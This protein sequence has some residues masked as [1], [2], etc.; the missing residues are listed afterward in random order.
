MNLTLWPGSFARF[1]R[2][3]EFG[4]KAKRLSKLVA[5]RWPFSLV[6]L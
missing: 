6:L 4:G 1:E 5:R 2:R 3:R